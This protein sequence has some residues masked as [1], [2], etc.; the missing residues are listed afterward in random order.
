M[1]SSA[2]YSHDSI[3]DARFSASRPSLV[4]S[5]ASPATRGAR[6]TQANLQHLPKELKSR[7]LEYLSGTT[8]AEDIYT[9]RLGETTDAQ[10]HFQRLAW[11]CKS[12]RTLVLPQLWQSLRLLDTDQHFLSR[13]QAVSE[14]DVTLHRI[15]R[16]AFRLPREPGSDLEQPP[17]HHFQHMMVDT[18]F[19]KLLVRCSKVQSFVLIPHDGTSGQS[20]PFQ[21]AAHALAQLPSL[22]ALRIEGV[23]DAAYILLLA[24][25]L[26]LLPRITL[27]DCGYRVLSVEGPA[28]HLESARRQLLT[29]MADCPRIA[30]LDICDPLLPTA[31]PSETLI[32]WLPQIKRL[33]LRGPESDD[34]ED[35]ED[36]LNWLESCCLGYTTTLD[37]DRRHLLRMQKLLSQNARTKSIAELYCWA[38]EPGFEPDD[39]DSLSTVDLAA[40]TLLGRGCAALA[41][42]LIDAKA[43]SSLREIE[44]VNEDASGLIADK[45]SL[46]AV[47]RWAA[48]R[49]RMRITYNGRR[50]EDIDLGRA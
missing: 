1:H 33:T 41:A 20:I 36:V 17:T 10:R 34:V 5:S 24:Q 7:I 16:L 40:L 19:S 37:T 6:S 39:L 47:H 21:R 3:T 22:T 25:L 50:L 29:S 38:Q 9:H 30:T 32:K 28:L 15:K 26:R 14:D 48:G 27:L 46:R 13:L 35:R 8:T 45:A 31:L 23:C 12:W 43:C 49:E 18:L 42:R 4:M 2:R 11:T 44:L